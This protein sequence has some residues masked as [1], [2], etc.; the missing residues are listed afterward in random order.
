MHA[1]GDHAGVRRGRRQ[2]ARG[3]DAVQLRHGDVHD[4]DV[5]LQAFGQFHGFAAVAGLADDLHVGLRAQD[6]FEAL[7]HHG[8]IVSEQDANCVSS[9]Q[10]HPHF[11]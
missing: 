9:L 10:G 11:N 4:H 2:A 6:H 5:G 1:Q 3:F 7:A 8:V